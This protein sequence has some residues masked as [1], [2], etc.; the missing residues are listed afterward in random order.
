MTCLCVM[1][2]TWG[3]D[4][5]LKGALSKS[6]GSEQGPASCSDVSFLRDW[7]KLK[8]LSVMSSSRE[9]I[10]LRN[11]KKS[12]TGQTSGPFLTQGFEQCHQDSVSSPLLT[13]PSSVEAYSQA[14]PLRS[15]LLAH[16][17][18]PKA[19]EQRSPW[20]WLGR[21]SLPKPVTVARTMQ[22]LHWLRPESHDRW[23]QYSCLHPLNVYEYHKLF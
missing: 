12:I 23:Q 1:V 20:W 3:Q 6:R 5:K 17:F 14:R 11:W 9:F 15:Q 4:R 19:P 2:Y 21:V 16:T 10:G 8:T 13:P 18:L 7:S 22:C